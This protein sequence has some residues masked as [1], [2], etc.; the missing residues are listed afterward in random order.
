M[1][2]HQLPDL[3]S[4]PEPPLDGITHLSYLQPSKPEQYLLASTSWDGSVRIHDALAMSNVCTQSMDCGPIMA[5]SA[6]TGHS[7]FTG[8]LDGSAKLGQIMCIL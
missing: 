4:L 3:R 2:Q 8:G 1:A 5:L 6:P 7:L